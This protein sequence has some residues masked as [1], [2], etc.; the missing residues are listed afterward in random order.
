[1]P[2]PQIRMVIAA[3]AANGQAGASEEIAT[4]AANAVTAAKA[5]TSQMAAV[6][7]QA[8]VVALL[9]AAVLLAAMVAAA[10]LA[11]VAAARQAAAT[12]AAASQVVAATAKARVPVGTAPAAPTAPALAATDQAVTI[13]AAEAAPAVATIPLP[14]GLRPTA[15]KR[16][17]LS[18]QCPHHPRTAR[19]IDLPAVLP[20][21]SPFQA[22]FWVASLA[23]ASL[24]VT[25]S[26]QV[27]P[28]AGARNGRQSRT[29]GNR[30]K[31]RGRI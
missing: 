5:G 25:V 1:M 29:A 8:A 19:A 2:Q 22:V 31:R 7:S 23:E 6:A 30:S 4:A 11:A 13:P 10:T 24:V 3:V 16:A 20:Q 12:A 9:V 21:K 18:L 14:P 28:S 17:A 26:L 15:R 27:D